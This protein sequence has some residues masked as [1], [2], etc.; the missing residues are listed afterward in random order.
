MNLGDR[1]VAA[2]VMSVLIGIT[3]NIAMNTK[4][5]ANKCN[6]T[7]DSNESNK[8]KRLLTKI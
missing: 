8:D 7:R 2:L 3:W 6:D 4:I 5:I 1:I